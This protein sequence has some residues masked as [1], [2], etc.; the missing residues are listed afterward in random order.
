MRFHPIY[1]LGRFAVLRTPSP[2]NGAHRYYEFMM[3]NDNRWHD[4]GTTNTPMAWVSN[5]FVW[6]SHVLW[7]RHIHYAPEKTRI[8]VKYNATT[9]MTTTTANAHIFSPFFRWTDIV[10]VSV[11]VSACCHATHTH[12]RDVNRPWVE[13]DAFD[14]VCLATRNRHRRPSTNRDFG[15]SR[16]NL[17]VKKVRF[18]TRSSW[19]CV[20]SDFDFF[21]RFSFLCFA[22]V[23][24]QQLCAIRMRYCWHEECR[25]CRHFGLLT[26]CSILLL[27]HP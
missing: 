18:S 13:F 25:C 20:G 3:L 21:R 16:A 7:S 2:S 10:C 9:T 8:R 15:S 11:S 17:I 24:S 12:T 27:W 14:S 23:H 26:W 6:I 5:V 22:C 1:S 4:G 19:N